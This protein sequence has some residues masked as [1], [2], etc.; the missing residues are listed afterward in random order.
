LV[1]TIV[2]MR[3]ADPELVDMCRSFCRSRTFVFLH[4]KLPSAASSIFAGLQIGVVL[5]LIGA[6]VGEFIASERGLG[7]LIG[8][9]TVNMNVSTMFA[10]VFILAAIGMTGSGIMRYVHRRAVFWEGARQSLPSGEV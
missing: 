3:Q 2:G 5:A 4:V 10:G 7:Y 8:S 1:N 9:A 6:V